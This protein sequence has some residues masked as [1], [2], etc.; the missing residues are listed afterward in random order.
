MAGKPLFPYIQMINE[1]DSLTIFWFTLHQHVN[2]I[3][4]S[5]YKIK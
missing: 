5:M 4:I 3:E 1:G 2:H